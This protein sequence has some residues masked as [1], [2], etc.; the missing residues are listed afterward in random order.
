M[1]IM[2]PHLPD[3]AL[4]QTYAQREDCFTDCFASP[5]QTT[6]PSLIRAFYTTPLF[7]VERLILRLAGYGS[8]DADAAALAA[9]GTT[10]AAWTVEARAMDQILL[11]DAFGRTRSWLMARDGVVY[12]G[13]AVVP[14]EP[15]APLGW[16]FGMLMGFHRIYSRALLRAAVRR[17]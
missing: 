8:T 11:Q 3:D 13:S 6:L 4:L 10:F 5:T 16:T 7:R 12:F 1:T 14:P 15:G 2:T 9:G 17:L